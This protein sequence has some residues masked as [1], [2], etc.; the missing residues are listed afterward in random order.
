MFILGATMDSQG[1]SRSIYEIH[2][3]EPHE[4]R[5]SEEGR[6]TAKNKGAA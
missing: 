2:G 4:Y 6:F 3:S 1:G 5:L